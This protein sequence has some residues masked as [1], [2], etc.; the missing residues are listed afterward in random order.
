MGHACSSAVDGELLFFDF[1]DLLANDR[2]RDDPRRRGDGDRLFDPADAGRA[3]RDD[4]GGVR[5]IDRAADPEPREPAA[6][7]GRARAG[8]TCG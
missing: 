7:A 4:V 3:R 2:T 8:R 6:A 1:F 5:G